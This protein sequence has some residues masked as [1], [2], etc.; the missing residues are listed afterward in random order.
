MRPQTVQ[1]PLIAA[2]KHPRQ[3]SSRL[4][5]TRRIDWSETS[6]RTHRL[7]SLPLEVSTKRRPR[8]MTVL[9][10]DRT[11]R[12]GK[13]RLVGNV[14]ERIPQTRHRLRLASTRG[15]QQLLRRLAVVLD[16]LDRGKGVIDL[17]WCFWHD[18][19]SASP[20]PRSGPSR[21]SA[22]TSP[23]NYC[24]VGTSLSA[25]RRRPRSPQ[26]RLTEMVASAL[27]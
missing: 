26:L 17:T 20:R 22:T 24:E 8:L 15:T 14:S 1:R 9:S 19:A 6:D 5:K 27:G 10:G 13:P 11:L 12:V 3:S 2:G 25:D 16:P 23:G 21:A 7:V 18:R 4:F